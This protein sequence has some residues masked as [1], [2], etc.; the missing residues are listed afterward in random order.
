LEV[1][2][3]LRG[4]KTIT[5]VKKGGNAKKLAASDLT[6]AMQNCNKAL[7]SRRRNPA[8]HAISH[9]VDDQQADGAQQLRPQGGPHSKYVTDFLLR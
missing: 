7:H 3:G 6:W 4:A 8:F 2:R 9:P 5:Y 1:G